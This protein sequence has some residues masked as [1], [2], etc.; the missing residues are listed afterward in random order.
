MRKRKHANAV[1]R[2]VTDLFDLPSELLAGLPR[3]SMA[4]REDLFVENHQGI[5]E[6]MQTRIRFQ[7]NAGAVRITGTDL[8]L[9]HMG[10]ERLAIHGGIEA[11]EF[12]P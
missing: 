4:G 12:L 5:I 7:T 10:A 8:V 9:K 3:I 2:T 11:V 6:C 1:L